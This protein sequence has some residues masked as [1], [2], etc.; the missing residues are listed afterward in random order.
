MRLR[1]VIEIEMTQHD[2]AEH[3]VT[4]V[5]SNQCER[6]YAVGGLTDQPDELRS[7][8]VIESTANHVVNRVVVSGRLGSN[9]EL[10]GLR[11]L[12]IAWHFK[13]IVS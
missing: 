4:A 8:L 5:L 13:T 3:S 11:C 6:W 7:D 10:I 12:S 2:V 9:R 1:A